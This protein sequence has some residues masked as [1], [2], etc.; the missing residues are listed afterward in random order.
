MVMF[1]GL[2][3][4]VS[5]GEPW[6]FRQTSLKDSDTEVKKTQKPDDS[7]ESYELN[8]RNMSSIR[9][10]RNE[11]FQKLNHLCELLE[12]KLLTVFKSR[13]NYQNS[14]PLLFYLEP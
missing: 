9:V 10:L 6:M 1:H 2:V 7:L 5:W 12:L 8:L 11:Q 14:L 13:T 3:D 4:G